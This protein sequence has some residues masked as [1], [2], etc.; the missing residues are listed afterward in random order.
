[1]AINLDDYQLDAISR[2]KVGSI[3][4]GGV[5]SG[6][7]RT[8]IGFYFLQNGGSITPYERMKPVPQDL[9]IIT[10]AQKRDKGE[11]LGDLAPFCLSSD[12][13]CSGY[14][15]KVIID[16]WNNIAK[17]RDIEDAFFLFDEQRVVGYG[18]WTKNFLNIAKHNEWILLTA[19]PA[20]C[21]S[22]YIP[23]F[24]ANG[25][26]KNKTDF[27]RQHC[28]FNPYVKY[29][30]VAGYVDQGRLIRYR[31]SILV[32]M[33]YH[34]HAVH[35]DEKIKC[36]YNRNLY[37]QVLQNRWDPYDNCPIENGSKFCYLLQRVVNSDP[38]R[39]EA[40]LELL[41]RHHKII[42]FYNYD[43][44]LKILRDIEYPLD[45]EFG[46]LN[47]HRHDPVPTSNVWLYFVQYR[48]GAE[49]WNCTTTDTML[50]YS[51]SYSYKTMVQ[52]KGRIDR[53]NTP[54][55]EL[56]YYYFKSNASI[57]FAISRSLNNKK[58]FNERR[59][60]ETSFGASR[61]KLPL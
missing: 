31:N 51:Q 49:A 36:N 34:S 19:T 44:E 11:W 45:V 9:Y 26:Y 38:S 41:H 1:M 56:Y 2:L 61:K 33:D 7:S 40:L 13:K 10:T 42:V 6:K 8:G 35:H 60:Y 12:P 4:V 20:D 32:D 27:E 48:A 53:R 24:I 23:V 14:P 28:Y 17:Y 52:A 30:S 15:N 47:G 21:W 43:Y 46:E 3:L 37:R 16:S 55:T 25:F 57:D 50:F 39:Q 5:G 58:D 54:F 59:F 29:R 18:A 22:D